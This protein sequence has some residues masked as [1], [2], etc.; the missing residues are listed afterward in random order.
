MS[1]ENAVNSNLLSLPFQ[2]LLAVDCRFCADLVAGQSPDCVSTYL[3]IVRR[4]R[5]ILE[6]FGRK[7]NES[8]TPFSSRARAQSRAMFHARCGL[9]G[10]RLADSAIAAFA[11]AR[12]GA[13]AYRGRRRRR[14]FRIRIPRDRP[15]VLAPA[16]YNLSPGSAAA[17]CS[18]LAIVFCL[19]SPPLPLPLLHLCAHQPLSDRSSAGGA[20]CASAA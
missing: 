8:S 17:S 10:R 2:R 3:R 15:E 7:R 13:R 1:S 18:T 14:S 9:G 6:L 12:P 20:A 5:A 19:S 16:R 11:S 4:M